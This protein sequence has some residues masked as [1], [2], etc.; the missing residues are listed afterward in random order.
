MF[1]YSDV[2]WTYILL[3]YSHIKERGRTMTF[4]EFLNIYANVSPDVRIQIEEILDSF[5]MMPVSPVED[6]R[7]LD[8]TEAPDQ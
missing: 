7:S 3:P 5:R 8:N 1:D 6:F 2:L 4:E